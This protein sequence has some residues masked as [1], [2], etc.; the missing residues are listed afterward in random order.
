MARIYTRHG[1]DGT[2]RLE[3]GVRFL[4]S[5]VRVRAVGEVDELISYVGLAR[6]LQPAE[7]PEVAQV[8]ENVERM[9]FDICEELAKLVRKRKDVQMFITAAHVQEVETACDEIYATL[10]PLSDFVLPGSA[11]ASAA[12]HVARSNVRRVE[13]TIV[14]LRETL[15]E[16]WNPNLVP[17]LNRLSSLFFSLARYSLQK[18]GVPEVQRKASP[19]FQEGKAFQAGQVLSLRL[20]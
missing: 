11:P 9:L 6:A 7:L 18:L 13:R 4:K 3:P 8:L 10:S 1:D 12:L 15:G 16:P 14:E 17:F 19:S 5:D 20:R 2:T